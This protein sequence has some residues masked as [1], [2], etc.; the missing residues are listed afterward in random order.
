VRESQVSKSLSHVIGWRTFEIICS[1]TTIFC[2]YIVVYLSN[3]NRFEKQRWNF[4][5]TETRWHGLGIRWLVM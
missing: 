5:L 3:E 2:F 4:T 1:I